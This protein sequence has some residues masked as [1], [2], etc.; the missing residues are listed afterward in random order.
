[1]RKSITCLI[2]G[3]LSLVACTEYDEIAMWNKNEDMGSRLSALE[4]LCSQMNTNITS[5][6]QIVEALQDNDYVTGVVPVVEN[7]Q[8]IGY[9]ITFTKSGPVTI[10]HGRDGQ[11]GSTPVIGVKQDTDGLYY[12]TLDGEWLLDDQNNKIVAQARDGKSA[13]E[14]AVEKGYQGTLDEWLASLNGS[15]GNDGKS[16]YELAVEKGYQG[17]IDEWLASLKGN[18]GNDGKSAYELAVEN[19]YQGSLDEWLASLNGSTGNDGK[20]AYELAVEN[21]YQGSLEEWLASLKGNA[22]DKGDDGITPRLEIRA[23]GYWYVSYDEGQSWTQL[24]QATGEPGQDGDSMFSNIDVTNPDYLILTLADGTTEIKVP[25]YRDQFDLLFV[26]GDDRVRELTLYCGADASVEATYELTNPLGATVSVECISHSAYQVAVD[27]AASKI[28]VTAPADPTA[29]AGRSEILVFASDDERTIMRKLVIMP[30]NYITYTATEQLDITNADFPGDPYFW[31]RD[32]EFIAEQSSYDALTGEGR[33]AYVG[34]VTQVEPNAFNG[35]QAIRSLVLPEGITFIG[36]NA[37]NNSTLESI[38]LPESLVEIDQYAFSKCNLTEITLP[39]NLARL[40]SS[41][42]DYEGTSRVSPLQKVV[43]EGNKLETIELNTFQYCKSLQEIV[44]PDGL[45]TIQYNAF[46]NCTSLLRI[47]I[48]NSVT[49]IGKSAFVYCTSLEE[50]IIG[51]GVT[52]IGSRAFG[53]CTALKRVVI[54]RGIQSIGDM[55]F[56]TRSSRDQMNLESVTV[57]FDDIDSGTFPV[58]A[59]SSR[60]VFPKPGGWDPVNYKIYVPAGTAAEYKKNWADYSSLIVE[61]P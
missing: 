28:T 48:P 53:E 27:R 9:T 47:E 35:S 17:T 10:Y 1:M 45:K 50:A 54:G 21:G 11:S 55:A 61:Q 3:I 15:A 13:Y 23:D 20:S 39:A 16:A 5:L 58:L 37:F 26:S 40:G 18:T 34:T 14:L 49:T 4:E 29:V 32:C 7:G 2:L 33:W 56:N 8:T 42:F 44:L 6:R 19:G 52:E 36:D 59:S 57:L 43:F 24:G 46:E 60:G 12:W 41:A 38:V 22:G 31:G 25:Y 51:D 30:V